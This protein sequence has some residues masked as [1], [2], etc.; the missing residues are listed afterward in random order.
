MVWVSV[1]VLSRHASVKASEKIA[2]RYVHSGTLA[3]RYMHCTRSFSVSAFFLHALFPSF[4]ALFAAVGM[5]PGQTSRRIT[6]NNT[7]KMSR[8]TVQDCYGY[9]RNL[10]QPKTD[11]GFLRRCFAA[12]GSTNVVPA[13][14]YPTNA[15]TYAISGHFELFG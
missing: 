1:H 9:H 14:Q 13:L 10:Q 6:R 7:S 4:I 12:A 2:L 8:L 11:Y 5:R 3:L 15:N